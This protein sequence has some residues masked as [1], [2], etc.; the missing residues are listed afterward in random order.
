ML[1]AVSPDMGQVRKLLNPTM[2]ADRFPE[3]AKFL[4]NRFLTPLRRQ[5]YS[6]ALAANAASTAILGSKSDGRP[7]RSLKYSGLLY[8]IQTFP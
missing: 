2:F 5:S 8:E 1:A 7:C 6:P 4:A 3:L